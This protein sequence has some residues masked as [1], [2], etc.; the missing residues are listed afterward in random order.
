MK[1][2]CEDIIWDIEDNDPN[3]KNLPDGVTIVNPTQDMFDDVKY[4]NDTIA[5]YLSDKYGYCT[6]GFRPKIVD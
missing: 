4:G 3:I 5:N 1:I 2:L 6:K